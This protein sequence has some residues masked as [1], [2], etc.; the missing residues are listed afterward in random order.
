MLELLSPVVH[1]LQQGHVVLVHCIQ[2]QVRSPVPLQQALT[3]I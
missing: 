1:L 2:G 3:A